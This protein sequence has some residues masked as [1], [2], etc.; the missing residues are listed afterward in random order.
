MKGMEHLSDYFKPNNYRLTLDINQKNLSYR[1]SIIISGEKT[2]ASVEQVKLHAVDIKIEQALINKTETEFTHQ[3]G[4]IIIPVG[5]DVHQHIEIK[6]SNQISSQMYGIY[7]CSYK[8]GKQEEL[9][10]ATQ[11]ESHYA[12]YAFPCIDEP[13]AKATFDLAIIA[14]ADYTILANTPSTERVIK[15]NRQLVRFETSPKMSTY[16]LGFV[17]GKLVKMAGL[18]KSGIQVSVYTSQAHQKSEL[19]YALK[20]ATRA[21]DWFEQ[22]FGVP[23]PLT[24]CDHVA[25]PD[26]AAGAMENWGLVTYREALL[27]S[28]PDTPID[29]KTAIATV[30]THELAHMWFGNLVT[31][32]WWD[33]LWLNE[34][35]AS[36]LENK[37]LQAIQP[38]L[39]ALDDYYA[40]TLFSALRRDSLPGV[41]PVITP[42]NRPE[43]ISTIFDGAI[44]YAKGACL[45]HM[46]E[47]WVGA[48]CFQAGL[49]SYLKK[50]AY[51]TAGTDDFLK[52]FDRLTQKPVSQVLKKWLHQAGFPL[53]EAVSYGEEW[54][55]RQQQFGYKTSQAW[56][57]PINFGGK[58]LL[59]KAGEVQPTTPTVINQNTAT[60]AVIKYSDNLDQILPNILKGDAVSRYYFLTCQLLLAENNYQ[61]Y[62]DIVP[63]VKHFSAS[64]DQLPWVALARILHN[65]KTIL[66]T[67]EAGLSA[68]QRFTSQQVVPKL[69]KI[70][71]IAESNES[72]NNY[73]L[74]HLLINLAVMARDA[75]ILNLLSQQFTSDPNQIDSDLRHNVIAAKLLQ[76]KD[77]SLDLIQS[78][79]EVYTKSNNP[80]LKND[81]IAGVTLCSWPAGV[82]LILEQLNKRSIIKPQDI[83]MWYAALVRQTPSREASWRWLKNNF[84]QL[85]SLFQASGDY[86]DFVRATASNFTSQE[87]LADFEQFFESYRKDSVLEREIMVGAEQIKAKASLIKQQQQAVFQ[88]LKSALSNHTKS[89]TSS[90]GGEP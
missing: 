71:L 53:I 2:D 66:E 82:N 76:D 55:I 43:E 30:V 36:I 8:L 84:E 34:S 28:Q 46:I 23:Y 68:L 65:L 78:L 59:I 67:S 57:I 87:H 42:I 70:G 31:M 25:L 63:L 52:I 7:P 64:Q 6:F 69:T 4:I 62:K 29:T 90:L 89:S 15:R 41:Q 37:C 49:Q 47:N 19:K 79:L 22:Y 44:V 9:I 12:R 58:Q 56:D 18:T 75:G 16:T 24:K 51:S 20:I 60:Y 77:K 39:Q 32:K 45:M 1:G 88:A 48:D 40:G 27:L 5:E 14:E 10:I 54:R 26:F 85:I 17:I 13:A 73:R 80:D 38:K 81:I 83:I 11:F 3:D 35:L 74:R 86:S 50:Y 61:P 72:I 21:L 33:E